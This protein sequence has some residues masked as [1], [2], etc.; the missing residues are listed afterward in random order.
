MSSE[1]SKKGEQGRSASPKDA[2][3]PDWADGLRQLYDSVVDEPLPDSFKDLLAK[4]D[5]DASDAS[6]AS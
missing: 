1:T 3:N 6:E 4:L 2:E 5:D